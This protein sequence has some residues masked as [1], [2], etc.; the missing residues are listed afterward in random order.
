MCDLSVDS[1]SKEPELSPP[2]EH[3]VLLIETVS[4]LHDDACCAYS[5]TA[6]EVV[7]RKIRSPNLASPQVPNSSRA[8]MKSFF[9]ALLV[10]FPRGS[11]L[12]SRATPTA[13]APTV[14]RS[15]SFTLT[16][17]YRRKAI[18]RAVFKFADGIS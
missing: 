3:V 9:R 10:H 5:D 7:A 18:D 16:N 2:A 14:N 11:R 1:K 13:A 12:A 6:D 8:R 15:V 17:E 4:I